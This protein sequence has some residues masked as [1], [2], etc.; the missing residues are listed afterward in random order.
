MHNYEKS[1]LPLFEE[2]EFDFNDV[3]PDDLKMD[4]RKSLNENFNNIFL[5]SLEDELSCIVIVGIDKKS[6]RNGYVKFEMLLNGKNDVLI[7]NEEKELN[8]TKSQFKVFA[9]NDVINGFF[10]G[11]D[12]TLMSKISKDLEYYNRSSL[13]ILLE[14]LKNKTELSK[15]DLENISGEIEFLNENSIITEDFDNS[16]K[17]IE[18]DRMD[19]ILNE[20]EIMP[21]EEI[22]KMS[23]TLINLTRLQRILSSQQVTVDSEVKHYVL[24]L[25]NGIK[26]FY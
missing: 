1:T 23:E 16:M 24:S 4:E 14:N 3:L 2:Y 19:N 15:E 22:M 7:C 8:L 26:K 21:K 9:Q 5:S 20:I 18:K 6:M 11:I 13:E 17:N 10:N 25:K 12:E